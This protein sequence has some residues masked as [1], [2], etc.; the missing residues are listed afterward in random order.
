ME[1]STIVVVIGVIGGG[2][3]IIKGVF[4]LL[5]FVVNNFINPLSANIK[6]LQKA[7]DDLQ[8][9]MERIKG[10]MH[11]L[12]RRVLILE[13]DLKAAFS[14]MDRIEDRQMAQIQQ[15]K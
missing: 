14:K 5:R 7:T 11:D 10:D 8:N 2:I 1:L 6:L 4:E 15:E 12:D 3:T 9:L 13:R